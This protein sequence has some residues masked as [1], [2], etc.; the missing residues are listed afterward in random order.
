[1]L[2]AATI[3]T[4]PVAGEW[5]LITNPNQTTS[6]VYPLVVRATDSAGGNTR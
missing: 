3:S 1:M 6:L 5:A 4:T 2:V